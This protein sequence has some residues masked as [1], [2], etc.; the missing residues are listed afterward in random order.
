MG[1]SSKFPK[2]L[3]FEIQNLQV[4][5]AVCLQ[6]NHNFMLNGQLTYDIQ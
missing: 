3:T 5:Q 6:N 1:E 4:K 2:I